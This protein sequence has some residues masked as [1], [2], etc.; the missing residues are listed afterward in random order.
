MMRQLRCD[1]PA[2]PRNARTPR[3]A[4]SPTGSRRCRASRLAS[5]SSSR[6][7]VRD[8]GRGARPR[9]LLLLRRVTLRRGVQTSHTLAEWTG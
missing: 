7:R 6:R 2:C 8:G 4:R 3:A 9:A 5:T 1:L